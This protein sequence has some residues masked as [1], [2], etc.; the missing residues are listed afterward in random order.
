MPM[1]IPDQSLLRG[2]LEAPPAGRSLATG[3]LRVLEVGKPVLASERQPELFDVERCKPSTT[4][5][6]F[7]LA[8]FAI[9][10]RWKNPNN[11]ADRMAA[12][13]HFH[14]ELNIALRPFFE[15]LPLGAALVV[16][17]RCAPTGN[18]ALSIRSRLAL[19]LPD[20]L[21]RDGVTETRLSQELAVCLSTLAEHYS[22]RPIK[23]ADETGDL[24]SPSKER[25]GQTV[26]IRPVS[27]VY[28]AKPACIGFTQADD[29]G[30]AV[31]FPAFE[32]TGDDPNS[33]FGAQWTGA[34]LHTF[35]AARAFQHAMCF[36]IRLTRDRLDA[37]AREMML[38][39]LKSDLS[40]INEKNPGSEDGDSRLS[41]LSNGSLRVVVLAWSQAN[42]AI[43]RIELEAQSAESSDM[44]NSLLHILASEIF[45][46]QR[47]ELVS[48]NA[49][50]SAGDSNGVVDFSN[51]FPLAAGLPPLLPQPA[52]LEMLGFTRHYCNPSVQLPRD[53]LLL[54]CAQLSGFEH[55]VRIAAADRS[56]HIYCL[57]GTGTGKST[58][59]YNM[60]VQ[61]M[62]AGEGIAVM[63]PASDF[64]DAVLAAVP[65]A[66]IKD[67]IIIDPSDEQHP[68]GLNPLDFGGNPTLMKV[69]RVIND[70]LDIFN[71]L[72]NMREAGGPGFEQYFRNTLLL[73]S[74]VREDSPHG[75]PTL[76]TPLEV[77]R[78]K[79]FRDELLAEC[80]DS[81]LG[82]D[83]AGEVTRFFTSAQATSGEQQFENWVP[84]VTNKL[85]R[86]TSNPLLRQMLCSPKRTVDFR[87]LMDERKILL[88]NL[89]KGEIGS[90]DTRMLGM[91]V[92]KY[93]FQAA[94]TRTDVPRAARI[95]FYCYVDEFHNFVDSEIA[96]ILA[97]ARKWGLHMV[98]AHQSLG[99]L[100]VGNTRTV[101][102]AV[103]G[104]VATKLFFRVGLDE[105]QALEPGYLPQFD[106]HTLAQLPDRHVLA[107][108]LVGNKPS[109]PFVFQT[110][111]PHTAAGTPDRLD[112]A[113]KARRWSREHYSVH[114]LT[115]SLVASAGVSARRQS[116]L[117][118]HGGLAISHSA[119]VGPKEADAID[120]QIRKSMPRWR[121][122]ADSVSLPHVAPEA[123]TFFWTGNRSLV[124]VLAIDS[125]GDG[126]A[127]VV[128][129]GHGD[130][131]ARGDYPG[132]CYLV[133][134]SGHFRSD[135]PISSLFG[136]D[137]QEK[138]ELEFAAPNPL[139]LTPDGT[140]A[141]LWQM[142]EH[143]PSTLPS[144][145]RGFFRTLNNS[146]VFVTGDEAKP[147]L[148]A[149]VC[150]GGHAVKELNGTK[151]GERYALTSLG[152]FLVSAE[153]AKALPAASLA[154]ASGM[155]LA[156]SLPLVG[157]C[158]PV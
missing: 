140:F 40:E 57:G 131:C 82:A 86:F 35:K 99:Q 63:D 69:N 153:K 126:R 26:C 12:G 60:V 10:P 30:S 105:A 3:D 7:E 25:F 146:V 92:L 43:L 101:L 90:Q 91:L 16:K 22:F 21:S 50:R 61:D 20:F 118:L 107:R 41:T 148:C 147:S 11:E 129:G 127:L 110:K 143:T 17:H 39:L 18:G 121:E 132:S 96:D 93:L 56:R 113:R 59:L 112:V 128:E 122:A 24:L 137:L 15:Q 46:G 85:V 154:L 81:F 138:A 54:G 150:S 37:K 149:T 5:P 109:L 156:A 142:V 97:E 155:S 108:L 19:E 31:W 114:S 88:V 75:S 98:L 130:S 29:N 141:W 94:M 152:Q 13:R 1:G 120:V 106:A 83:M 95:P 65:V 73:A 102:D 49:K 119:N 48:A 34:L 133:N 66:R 52:V 123:G 58:L 87:H 55:P 44:S 36:R 89:G 125:D 151:L 62:Q 145:P 70:L 84:Y 104:N 71:S 117:I 80:Y 116:T 53:G 74:T 124:L 100:V 33:V 157:E 2:P 111:A 68:V 38:Q 78:N 139:A 6:V 134:A 47:V 45:P 9:P 23:T 144:K 4:R 14:T 158:S 136:M 115:S 42:P 64:V 72:Y 28:A 79:E 8:S 103:L 51:A 135:S 76:L 32:S 67:V 77:L 27:V